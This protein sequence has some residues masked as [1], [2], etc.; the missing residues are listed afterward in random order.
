MEEGGAK[1]NDGAADGSEVRGSKGAEVGL[2][3]DEGSNKD[4]VLRIWGVGAV[5]GGATGAGMGM[6]G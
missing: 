6:R 2:R 4:A 1:G 5:F 3:V